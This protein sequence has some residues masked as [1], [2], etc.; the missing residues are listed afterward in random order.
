MTQEL[1][2]SKVLAIGL[3]LIGVGIMIWFGYLAM[4]PPE[5]TPPVVPPPAEEKVVVTVGKTEY[6]KGETV[7]ISVKNNLAETVFL[8]GCNQFDLARKENNEWV[9]EQPLKMCVWEGNAVKIY[10][11]G[12]AEYA[13]NASKLGTF[14]INV[15]YS[16]GC[17][18]KKP[19]SQANC[20]ADNIAYSAEFTV[21][22]VKQVTVGKD[23][24]ITLPANPSTGYSWEAQF[25]KNYL[26]LRSKDFVNDK[27][28]EPMVGVGGTE[29]F[30]FAPIKAGETTV[31]MGYGRSWE[32]KPAETKVFKYIIKEESAVSGNELKFETVLKGPHNA[33]AEKKNYIIK[34]QAEWMQLL[35]K[36]GDELIAPIDFNKDMVIAVF[37]GQQPTGGYAT[38]IMKILETELNLEV[39]IKEISPGPNCIVT[40]ALTNPYHIVKLQ[41]SAKEVLINVAKEIT[42]CR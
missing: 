26:S 22:E 9:M 7:R 10:S 42:D 34:T 1:A 29:V 23:F 30:T 13:F 18:D 17:E 12:I 38:E 39:R 15:G 20:K 5:T 6:Q 32:S 28:S 2:K 25:D 14:R 16:Q 24:L 35:Q 33:N 11:K 36:I 8:G 27:V 4:N 37:Q 21:V 19:V 3:G 40:Q 31:L 41:K